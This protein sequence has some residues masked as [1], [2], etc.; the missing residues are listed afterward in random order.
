MKKRSILFLCAVCLVFFLFGCQNHSPVLTETPPVISPTPAATP[1]PIPESTASPTPQVTPSVTPFAAQ[2]TPSPT[3]MPLVTPTPTPMVT[4]TPSETP[5]GTF[6]CTLSVRCDT[7][8][9]KSGSKADTIPPSGVF[10]PPTIV[11]V[12]EGETAFDVLAR[13]MKA[14]GIHFEFTGSVSAK[15]AY[16]EGIGNLY[17][18]DFGSLSGWMYKV[19]GAFPVVG[20]ASCILQPDDTIEWLYSCDLGAD[21]GK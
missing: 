19:N 13:E 8:V 11:S 21:L 9:G 6:S 4:P 16:V 15:T 17:E 14:H 2:A 3:V 1:S 12:R 5:D 7:A 20:A 10:L 18:Q